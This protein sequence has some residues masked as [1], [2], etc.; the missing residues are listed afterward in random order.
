[1]RTALG[2]PDPQP[3]R[4]SPSVGTGDP[5]RADMPGV[6]APPPLIFGLALVTGL[7]L[8]WL[9]PLAD[10]PAALR[11]IAGLALGTSGLLLGL[12]FLTTLRRAG[13]A[14]DTSKP[15]TRIVTH[16]PFRYTRN[17]GYVSLTLSYSGLALLSGAAWALV[18]LPFVLALVQRTVVEREE[19]YLERKFGAE[20]RSY[21]AGVRRWV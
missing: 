13:T 1:M 21:R 4:Q 11:W 6:L 5:S 17:P 14:I 16:G 7:I 2:T 9:L 3:A 19:R 15:T 8:E 10:F 12:W 18:L 20:Y